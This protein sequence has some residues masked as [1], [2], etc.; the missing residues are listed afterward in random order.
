MRRLVFLLLGILELLSGIL[1]VCFAWQVPGKHEVEETAVRAERITR[2]SGAQVQRLR[3]QFRLF[4]ERRPQMQALA[5]RLQKEMKVVNEHL[6]TQ[7][8]DYSTVKI[9]SDALGD[10]ANGLDGLSS[11]L[12]PKSM[13]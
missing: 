5:I 11:S 13:Q 4:R 7:Q 6:K 1:L 2:N 12:D 10:A 8:L 3:V 9:L